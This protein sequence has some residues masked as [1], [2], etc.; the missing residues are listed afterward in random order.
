MS[1][2]GMFQQLP[3][4]R[5]HAANRID[6]FPLDQHHRRLGI[7]F[8]HDDQQRADGNADIERREAAGNMKQ[9]DRQ[10]L[11]LL[12]GLRAAYRRGLARRRKARICDK[13]VASTGVVTAR[14]LATAPFG[15]PD[16]PDV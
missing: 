1:A 3:C 4:D 15:T 16:V 9:R 5:G 6:T 12:F 13:S 11:A 10:K 8:A 2:C 14:W 7:P